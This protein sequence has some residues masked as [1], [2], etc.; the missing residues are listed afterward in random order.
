MHQ[1]K[2]GIWEDNNPR[3]SGYS[4]I[5]DGEGIFVFGDLKIMNKDR[6]FFCLKKMMGLLIV[7]SVIVFVGCE[8]QNGQNNSSQSTG[9]TDT[10]QRNDV[11]NDD[12]PSM[13]GQTP[14]DENNAVSEN[15]E[16]DITSNQTIETVEIGSDYNEREIIK[17]TIASPD[18]NFVAEIVNSWGREDGDQNSSLVFRDS[19]GNILFEKI[20]QSDG[21]FGRG[22]YSCEV[23]KN[24]AYIL[25]QTS[26]FFDNNQLEVYDQSGNVVM[27]EEGVSEH[28]IWM[29]PSG[30]YVLIREILEKTENGQVLTARLRK[31]SLDGNIEV[32]HTFS[33]NFSIQPTGLSRNE[34]YYVIS[35]RSELSED[36]NEL[37]SF[38]GDDLL[39]SKHIKA[40]GGYTITLSENNKYVVARV[41]IIDEI[42]GNRVL[43][44]H[45]EYEIFEN[46]NGQMVTKGE[47]DQTQVDAYINETN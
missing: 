46:I 9:T 6:I 21:E 19:R 23:M 15:P 22:I 40:G 37:L 16:N 28:D 38:K 25:I 35:T 31:M 2:N 34:E 41:M 11:N 3:V 14:S 13:V 44:S 39:W 30:E 32:V 20:T 47:L 4:C 5:H 33:D 43:R 29:A 36:H 26:D 42:Q 1:D 10:E 24:G 18:G 45:I 8:E 12:E 27:I 7:M 17:K